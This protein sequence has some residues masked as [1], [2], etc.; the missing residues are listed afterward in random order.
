ME[1]VSTNA[2]SV[3]GSALATKLLTNAKGTVVVSPVSI[4]IALAMAEVASKTNS[5]A[6]EQLHKLLRFDLVDGDVHTWFKQI[7][8]MTSNTDENVT[9]NTA[10]AVFATGEVKKEFLETCV[11]TFS[12]EVFN[13][14]TRVGIND[15]VYN[16]TDEMIPEI[17]TRDPDGPVVLVNAVYFKG[18]W[19]KKFDKSLTM[20]GEFTPFGLF[21]VRCNMMSMTNKKMPYKQTRHSEIV[22]L[23]YGS[24]G[25]FSA[26]VAVPI[27]KDTASMDKAVQEFFGTA[28]SWDIAT[29]NMRETNVKLFLPRFIAEGGVDDLKKCIQE[30][31]VTDVFCSGGTPLM[32]DSSDTFI[33]DVAHKARIKVDENGTT[34]SAATVVN[35]TRGFSQISVVK[36]DRPFLFVILHSTTNTLLFVARVNSIGP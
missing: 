19:A 6:E 12:A 8:S 18:G 11:S 35:T 22:K 29:A 20:T 26:F 33:S 2:I 24:T 4:W 10:N 31:G 32:T 14:E 36:A 28:N 16:N 17:L 5:R 15:F 25:Q 23:D 1:T 34:A 7:Q 9:L 21:P 30:M 3:F 27:G 13:L